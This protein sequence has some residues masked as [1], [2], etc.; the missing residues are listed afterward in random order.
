MAALT[1]IGLALKPGE[2]EAGSISWLSTTI[3]HRKVGMSKRNLFWLLLVI[4][5]VSL[6]WFRVALASPIDQLSAE[7]KAR[8][9][10]KYR[11][12]QSATSSDDVY[13]TPD[14]YGDGEGNAEPPDRPLFSD[15]S[16][17]Q[18]DANQSA[19][20]RH[21]ELARQEN[22]SDPHEL[23]EFS[24]LA[25]FGMELFDGPHDSN[26]PAD[27]SASDDY[28]LG[29]GDHLIVY[30]WG[31]AEKEYQLTVDREGKVFIP[32]AGEI[33]AWGLTIEQ[34]EQKAQRLLS[35]VYSDFELNVSL[36]KIRSM[37][38]YV[39]GEVMKPGAY[40]VSSLTSLFNAIYIA[41]GPNER[42]SM[43]DIQLMR[44]GKPVATVD[45]YRLLLAGDNSTD[46]RLRT[47][48][49]VFVPVSGPRVA[50]RGEIKRPA[51]YELS[52]Q[53]TA[54]DLLTLAGRPTAQAY[55]DRVMLE[56]VSGNGEWEVRDLDLAATDST[57]RT[58][59]V[60]K[61]GD[62]L[63]IFSIF[64]AKKN[65]VAVFGH[66]KHPGY[67]ERNETTRVSEIIKRAQLQPY[68]VYYQRADLFRRFP[69]RR[70]EVIPV[71]LN[72]VLAGDTAADLALMDHDSLHVYSLMDID[73]D[74]FVYIEGEVK[75]PGAFPLYEKMTVGDL[76][77]LS[78]SYKRGANPERAEIARVDSTGNVSLIYLNLKNPGDLALPL[79]EDDQLY[80][81]QIPQW[82]IRRTITISGEVRY[83]GR[84]TL[85]DR[86]ETLWEM[87]QRAGGFTTVAFPKGIVLQ[88]QSI[89][90]NLSQLKVTDLI[91]RTKPVVEDSLGNQ[92]R[93]E[94]FVYDP[95]SLN[96][97]I[98]D[99]EKIIATNGREG[100]VVLE[101]GDRIMVPARP[102]GVSIMGAVAA[103][104][105]I[106]FVPDKRIEYY[107]KRAG[108]YTRQADKDGTRLIRTWGEV[109]SDGNARGAKVEMGDVVVVPTK[110]ERDKNWLKTASVALSAVTAALTSVFIVS[111]L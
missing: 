90:N 89:A 77:F 50:I 17:A 107:I 101:P 25:P 16:M 74:R 80:V 4:I 106:K 78:G 57:E 86:S 29:P 79:C 44:A 32:T 28:Q 47:G 95:Q 82:E 45:L 12:S 69:D 27:V 71:D 21:R 34:F 13:R 49:V 105:T 46:L 75:S 51:V 88:R 96:R 76:I 63:T 6:N 43:R 93:D 54:R 36:G 67:F 65:M 56:R 11:R 66:V 15:S 10:E 98:I 38:I 83:P 100:D 87:L 8:L 108:N 109:L 37:R 62:R 103:N 99:M 1:G 85:A 19:L 22:A 104:G 61:D 14:L 70:V 23:V 30:L 53:Q 48:D 33:V 55:L 35:T 64:Q 92:T 42:G 18:P 3:R 97:I 7:E 58:P 31:R 59:F 2:N 84:Y 94:V 24:D 68:D 39:T 81:R 20:A 41:G 52:G 9:I 91:D 72:A 110:V 26:P 60:L 73:R 102:S 111:K 5:L 40:T